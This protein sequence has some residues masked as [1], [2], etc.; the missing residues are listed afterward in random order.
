MHLISKFNEIF[1]FLLFVIDIY[2]KHAWVI[3]LK[4]EKITSI[5]NAFQNILKES[6]RKPNN[7]WLDKDIEFYSRSIELWIEK[8]DIEIYSTDNEGQFVVVERFIITFRIFL[9]L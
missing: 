4:N 6:N 8:R 3:S 9:D 5:T 7:M 2:G 1:W